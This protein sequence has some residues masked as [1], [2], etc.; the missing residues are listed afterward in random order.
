MK[1]RFLAFALATLAGS[2]L[3]FLYQ[4]FPNALTALMQPQERAG[5]PGRGGRM[6]AAARAF[7]QPCP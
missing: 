3:H 7:F 2:C 6:Q 4:I 5:R 1:K